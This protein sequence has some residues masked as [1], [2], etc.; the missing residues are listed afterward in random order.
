M[1]QN[2]ILFITAISL[3]IFSIFSHCQAL[4]SLEALCDV[5]PHPPVCKSVLPVGSPGSVSGFASIVILKSLEASR[6]LLASLNQHHSTSGPLDDC[7]LLAGLTVDQLTRVNVIKE[8]V[9]G[10]TEVNDILTLLSAA[11]TNYETCLGSFHDVTGESSENFVKDHHDILTRVS[12]GIKLISVSLA[13]S[14]NAWPIASD[15]SGRKPPPRILTEEK[16]SSSPE[17]SYVKVAERERMIYERVKVLGRK[18]LQ[19]SPGGI[20]VAKTVVVNRNDV[21]G[22]AFKT[23]N[24]AVAAAPTKAES[25]NGYFVIYVVAGVY[26]EYVTVPSNKSYVMIIGDGIDKTIITGNRNVVDGSTT[27][28]SATLALT[29]LEA[30]C[31]VTPHPPVCKS[32]LPVGSPGSVSGFASI[33]ILKS[34]EASRHLL[35]SLN[36][37]HSTSGPLDDCQL[38][39]GLTVD[40]LTRVNVIKETV[41]GTTE[42]NDILTL[43]SAA[44]TNYETCLGSFHDVTGESS[45]NFVKDHHDILTRVSEGIKLISVSLALSKNAWPIASDASGRKPPPRILTEEKKS[46]SPEV[47]Y[48]KVAERERMIYERVKVLGRKL[49]QSSPGG[50][51]VAKTVV[52]NRNDVNGDAF[53]TINDAYVTVPSNK[54]YV[55]IIGDG[56]DKTIITGNRNVVD[57]STT[58]ASAT[59]AVVGRGFMAANITVRNTAGPTKHQAVAVRNSA[60]MS[61]FYK[62]SFEAYQ[63]TLYVHSL[64]QFYRECDIY[65]TVDFIFGNAATVLQN[66]NIIPRLPLQ[67]Q[68]N[69]IT[70][71]GRSD[72]NQNTGISIQNCKIVPSAELVSSNYSVKTYLGRPW[73]EYSR[74]VYLQNFMDGFI[75]AKGWNEWMGDFALQSLYYAEFK[76]TGPGSE[77]AYRVNWPGYHVINET[78]A[79]WFT[80]SSFI[81]GDSWLPSMGV[82]YTGGLM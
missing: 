18:L 62:C 75:D 53:K 66:C 63:D 59:L 76:N 51:K 38:L 48:V 13:L 58:F 67:G 10:T 15:A 56:I 32:V 34:L 65:G 26:E 40:Q 42:V 61:A 69:A 3:L 70:A 37:H 50:I 6:H 27:F 71:Q 73:K 2:S 64:R 52:V 5:T 4:T 68:F 14:K 80:V 43:L 1:A 36:Q 25:E 24:D 44:L 55:M 54:S 22:D 35:A 28:A 9:P 41:P 79:V 45:E 12:E 47:S 30:L 49:L 29:S 19:S 17:V 78:E 16:K 57:G 33:V 74:T 82:P 21:N 39:A 11:L 72:P 46:S 60:D 8:T 23:I 77:T 20:K 31:D 81:V 7:Q